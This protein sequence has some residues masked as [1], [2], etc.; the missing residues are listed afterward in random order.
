MTDTRKQIK[1]VTGQLLF[2]LTGSICL[3]H[4]CTEVDGSHDIIIRSSSMTKLCSHNKKNC[5]SKLSYIPSADCLVWQNNN[6][7]S[8]SILYRDSVI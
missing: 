6:L 1:A 3:S 5:S 4:K 2:H 8:E 7:Y